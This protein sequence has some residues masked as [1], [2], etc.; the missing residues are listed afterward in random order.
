MNF[1]ADARTRARYSKASKGRR[2][3]IFVAG[4]FHVGPLQLETRPCRRSVNRWL[5][6]GRGDDAAGRTFARRRSRTVTGA[7]TAQATPVASASAS[8]RSSWRGTRIPKV[9]QLPDELKELALRNGRAVNRSFTITL[10]IRLT[11]CSYRKCLRCYNETRTH[12]SLEQGCAG[13]VQSRQFVGSSAR[14]WGRRPIIA[15]TA[16]AHEGRSREVPWRPA[17]RTRWPSR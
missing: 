3:V 9:D 5:A 1:G 15:V 8:F 2:W 17:H 4:S 6:K 12:L 16:K 13:L 7:T 11:P 14:S 10:L